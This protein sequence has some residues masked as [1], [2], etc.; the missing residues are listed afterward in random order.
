MAQHEHISEFIAGTELTSIEGS[1][2][3]RHFYSAAA[4]IYSGTLSYASW[5]GGFFTLHRQLPPVAKYGV[6]AYPSFD[7]PVTATVSQLTADWTRFLDVVPGKVLRQTAID[8]IGIPAEEGAYADPWAWN[9]QHGVQD[10]EVQARWFEAACDAAATAHLRGIFFWNANLIDN[11]EQ[12]FPSLVKF[13]N[14]P[15]SEAAIRDCGH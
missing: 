9:N 7:L 8:E 11:P 4:K 10:N 5:G 2:L 14:R 13:E 1:P 15:N 6:T 3:W 12:P